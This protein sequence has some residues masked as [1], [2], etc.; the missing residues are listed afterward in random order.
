M[1]RH[2]EKEEVDDDPEKDYLNE[3]ENVDGVETAKVE[4]GLKE[5]RQAGRT[6]PENR[7]DVGNIG[8]GLGTVDRLH[9]EIAKYSETKE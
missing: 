9:I 7:D 3:I 5:E 4:V 8:N 1:R 2:V 6:E